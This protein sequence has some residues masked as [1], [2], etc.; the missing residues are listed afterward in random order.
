M[1]DLNENQN[2][3]FFD[4]LTQNDIM[5]LSIDIIPSFIYITLIFLV[6]YS[7]DKI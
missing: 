3:P 1:N 4:K 6:I 2:I 5:K 7:T